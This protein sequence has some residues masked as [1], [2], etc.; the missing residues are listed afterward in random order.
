MS[1]V[2]VNKNNF[3]KMLNLLKNLK[4]N[5]FGNVC[6]KYR[7]NKLNLS[8]FGEQELPEDYMQV[9]NINKITFN[10]DKKSKCCTQVCSGGH[11]IAYY[12]LI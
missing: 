8:I 5:P 6:L 4:N 1:K 12:I 11:K 7:L 2:N 3:M 9:V 10:Y